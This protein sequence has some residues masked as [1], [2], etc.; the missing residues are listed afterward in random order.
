[1]VI[2]QQGTILSHSDSRRVG[3][4]IKQEGDVGAL[5]QVIEKAIAGHRILCIYFYLKNKVWNYWLATLQLTVQLR[6]K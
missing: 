2:N 3:R 1:V 6:L 4:N 5:E